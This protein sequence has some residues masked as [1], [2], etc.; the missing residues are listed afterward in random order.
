M[1]SRPWQD[2]DLV[3][4]TNVLIHL[5]RY[6][7]TG[8]WILDTILRPRVTAPIVSVV[9]VAEARVFAEVNNWPLSKNETLRKVLGQCI[10]RD[11]PRDDVSLLDAYRAIDLAS[12]AQGRKMG[13]ND[14]WIAA[15]CRRM[16]AVLFTSDGD[17]DHLAASGE[18]TVDRYTEVAR[19]V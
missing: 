15:E 4:D 16:G 9:S 5:G 11:V 13:K 10:V 1:S 7:R 14:I 2:R 8:K 6:S 3:L 12:R 19:G 17:F 18:L